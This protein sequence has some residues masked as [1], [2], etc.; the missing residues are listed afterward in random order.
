M[1]VT[2]YIW[3][4]VSNN[5]RLEVDETGGV[6]AEYMNEPSQFGNLLSQRRSSTNSFYHF[7][8][9]GSTRQLTTDSQ[10]VSDSYTYTAFGE[11]VSRTGTTRNPF[12]FN[13]A[14]GYYTDA[15][16]GDVYAE[17]GFYKAQLGRWLSLGTSLVMEGNN[18]YSGLI[19]L[20]PRG[21]ATGRNE[22]PSD[23]TKTCKER[24]WD[25]KKPEDCKY[26]DH[27]RFDADFIMTD[28]DRRPGNDCVDCEVVYIS[29]NGWAARC[30][31]R[32]SWPLDCV[33]RNMPDSDVS[34]CIRGCLMCIYGE[35]ESAAD[36]EEHTWCINQCA[37]IVDRLRVYEDLDRTITCCARNV[38]VILGPSLGHPA[39]PANVTPIDG[40]YLPD[41][42]F[43]WGKPDCD[44]CG[45]GD[46]RPIDCSGIE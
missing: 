7:D 14:W 44:N 10:V 38:G 15:E 23:A 45:T 5:V 30:G 4:R 25:P 12:K 19:V 33:C 43:V 20:S 36:L 3:D 1:P 22:L 27:V 6:T 13:G 18:G 24:G 17:N 32:I 11:A 16:T 2:N 46:T 31:A 9:Q 28:K 35:K 8:A 37:G 40:V 21:G 34:N 39:E 26:P 42:E 29:R 41:K